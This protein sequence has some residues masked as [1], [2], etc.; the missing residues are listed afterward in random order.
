[1]NT[2]NLFRFPVRFT[3]LALTAL[4][5][6]GCNKNTA[7]QA[8]TDAKEVWSDTKAATATMATD[9]KHSMA[10]AWD[11]VANATYDRREAMSETLEKWG[12]EI[13]Q[14]VEALKPK[15][16]SL[17]ASAQQAYDNSVAKLKE[18]R[19]ELADEMGDL[20]QATAE[21]WSDAKREVQHAWEK[22]E[23]AYR[24]LET[25]ATT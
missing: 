15:R 11:S 13:D 2:K 12:D 4:A 23:N 7:E 1:M 3:A 8:K 22:V 17:S 25:R 21:T 18:A 9:A 5:F 14:K 6:A 24:D 20:Q 19:A 10:N 16:D